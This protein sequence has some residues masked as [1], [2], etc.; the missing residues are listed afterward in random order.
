MWV[1]GKLSE[2]S[3]A[4][5]LDHNNR[6]HVA[7]MVCPKKN[8]YRGFYDVVDKVEKYSANLHTI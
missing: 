8:I 6:Q 1:A 4:L 2:L 3:K 7:T 5:V